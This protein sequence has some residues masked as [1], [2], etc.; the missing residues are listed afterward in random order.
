MLLL[1]CMLSKPYLSCN[2][3]PVLFLLWIYFFTVC[4]IGYIYI[5]KQTHRQPHPPTHTHN[6]YIITEEH[7]DLCTWKYAQIVY[8]N[9]L[10]CEEGGLFIYLPRNSA[11]CNPP[12][13]TQRDTPMTNPQPDRQTDAPIGRS[14]GCG[15]GTSWSLLICPLVMSLNA[16]RL[17]WN[18]KLQRF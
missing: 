3:L 11:N 7:G 10:I 15:R 16:F 13:I 17:F 8:H 18:W 5:N 9:F 4:Y 14:W 1:C 2:E 12:I 6:I